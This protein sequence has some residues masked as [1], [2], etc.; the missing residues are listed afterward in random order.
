MYNI[1][2]QSHI[3]SWALLVLLFIISYIL[4]RAGKAKGQKITHMI[5]R[6]FY[7]IMVVSGLGML[8]QLGFPLNFSIKAVIGL[9]LIYVME[10]LLVRTQKGVLDSKQ[11]TYYWIQLIVS[12]IIVVLL[13]FRVIYF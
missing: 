3:G 8:F 1:F 4:L 13:G 12:L 7:V 11:T 6:L 5:L 9:W 2:Y 10:I